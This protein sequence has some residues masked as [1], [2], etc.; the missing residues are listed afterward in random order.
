MAKNKSKDTEITGLI[1]DEPES[2]IE[3]LVEEVIVVIKL[4]EQSQVYAFDV[5]NN[6]DLVTQIFNEVEE[7]RN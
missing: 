7:V 3:D 4:K 1:I 6:E 2:V 5:T